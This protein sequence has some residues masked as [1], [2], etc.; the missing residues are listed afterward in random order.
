VIH[1]GTRSAALFAAQLPA[2]HHRTAQPYEGMEDDPGAGARWR[3][4]KAQPPGTVPCSSAGSALPNGPG[5]AA[6]QGPPPG[7]PLI[8][9]RPAQ[10]R[11]S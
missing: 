11:Q 10:R 8:G 4:L 9:R 2:R 3:T 5:E 7:A 1:A 6:A